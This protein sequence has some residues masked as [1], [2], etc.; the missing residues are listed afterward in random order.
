ML[1]TQFLF[2]PRTS[3]GSP[4]S[5]AATIARE[6]TAWD[7]HYATGDIMASTGVDVQR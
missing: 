7:P 5:T 2:G 4:F 1:L 6:L 3:S